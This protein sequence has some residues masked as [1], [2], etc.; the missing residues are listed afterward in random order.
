MDLNQAPKQFCDN[1]VAGYSPEF[2]VLVLKNGSNAAAYSLTPGHA[3]RLA[4]YMA[5]Q[6]AEYEKAHGTIKSEWNI[7]IQSPIQPGDLKNPG[8][9]PASGEEK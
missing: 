5:H 8:T 4:Q 9:G 2:F 7:N 3:K 6:V 1:I